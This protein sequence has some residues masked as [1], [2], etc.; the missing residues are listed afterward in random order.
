MTYVTQKS[1]QYVLDQPK[2]EA[3]ILCM[4]TWNANAV[5][6]CVTHFLASARPLYV[7]TVSNTHCEMVIHQILMQQQQWDLMPSA[8]ISSLAISSSSFCYSYS[9]TIRTVVHDLFFATVVRRIPTGIC[10]RTPC[11]VLLVLLQSTGA[12]DQNSYHKSGLFL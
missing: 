5:Y 12:A 11:R 8:I 1:L 10:V 9:F 2:Y 7:L 4:L 6:Y 3:F